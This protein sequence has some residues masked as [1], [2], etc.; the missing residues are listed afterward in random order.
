VIWLFDE[1]LSLKERRDAIADRFENVYRQLGMLKVDE[2]RALKTAVASFGE[3]THI[4]TDEPV[5]DI[6]EVIDDVRNIPPDES[7]YENVFAAVQTVTA[8]WLP[9]RTKMRR[10]VMIVIVTDERGDDFDLMDQ[11][12]GKLSRY[13]IPVYCVGNAAVFGREKGF[14]RWKYEDGFEEDLP[15]DQGPETVA[16]ER[17]RLPF[18][19]TNARDLDQMSSGFGPYALTRLCAETG[20]MYLVADQS[21]GP[22]F[23]PALMRNYLPDF[24]PIREYDEQL[25]SNTAKGALVNVARLTQD[26]NLNAGLMQAPSLRRAFRADT[27]NALRQ[28]ITEAQRP[29]AEFDFKMRELLTVLEQGEKDREKLDS[30]RWQASYDLAMGRVLAMTVRAFGYNTV[31]ADMKSSPKTFEKKDSNQWKLV[32]SNEIDAGPAVKKLKARASEYLTRVIDEHPGTPWA[33]LAERELG[34]PMGWAWEEGTMV[35]PETGMT[36]GANKKNIQLAEEQRRRQEMERKKAMERAK[37]RP[38][39]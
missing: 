25:R 34:T 1:S 7:G 8:K 36:G 5:D 23:D 32:P 30:P 29:A 35:I 31:L 15:V 4:I 18:W 3:R 10:N 27:D 19:G 6:T 24:R 28:E 38:K 11:T 26:D 22:N 14:V 17:L 13:G 2:A 37:A 39:L 20:G 21:N 33:M 9:F 12:I 16:P